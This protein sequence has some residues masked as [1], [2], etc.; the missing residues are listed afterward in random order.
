[1]EPFSR[2]RRCSA[3]PPNTHAILSPSS[4]HRWLN[5]TR[6]ARLELEFSDKETAAAAEG[7]GAHALCEHKVKKA[8]KQRSS[9]PVS[10][11]DSDEMEELTDAYRDYVIEKLT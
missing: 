5:C 2:K 3:M 9:R 6:S 11:F 7:T 10:Q 1:M 8:L 4:A